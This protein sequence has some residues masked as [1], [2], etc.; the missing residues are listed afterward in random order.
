MAFLKHK[1]SIIRTAVVNQVAK[2]KEDWIKGIKN[3]SMGVSDRSVTPEQ[4]D[5]LESFVD[6]W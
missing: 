5:V 4:K 1:D 3:T 2:E 6:K